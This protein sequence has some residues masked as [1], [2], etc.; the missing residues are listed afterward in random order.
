MSYKEDTSID[1]SDLENEWVKQADTYGE[2]VSDA[3]DAFE[4]LSNLKNYLKVRSA[5]IELDARSGK[6]DIGC[7][8]T[9]KAINAFVT[10]HPEIVEIENDIVKAKHEYDIYNGGVFSLEQKKRALENLVKLG[11]N[12]YYAGTTSYDDFRNRMINEQNS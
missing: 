8:V 7:K 2:Y 1:R 11:L 5:Q 9:D 12:N 3:N 10:S 4:A 6:V